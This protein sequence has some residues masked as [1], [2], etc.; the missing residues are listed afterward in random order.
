MA[1]NAIDFKT[2][3]S[4]NALMHHLGGMDE[5]LRL[6][7]IHQNLDGAMAATAAGEAYLREVVARAITDPAGAFAAG[8]QAACERL[9]PRDGDKEAETPHG[10]QGTLS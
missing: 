7:F 5:C 2:A 3:G 10:G 8:Y 4:L 1:E 9:A 6:G